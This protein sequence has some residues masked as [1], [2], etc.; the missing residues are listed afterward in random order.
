[1]WYVL[2]VYNYFSIDVMDALGFFEQM[3]I[4]QILFPYLEYKLQFKQN[5]L[6][7]LLF[8]LFCFSYLCIYLPLA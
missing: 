6:M 7:L 3:W 2:N 5:I 1:M 8:C 4:H